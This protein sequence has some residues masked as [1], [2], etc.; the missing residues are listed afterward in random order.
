MLSRDR[1]IIFRLLTCLDKALE[2]AARGL[3]ARGRSSPLR[4]TFTHSTLWVPFTQPLVSWCVW[5]EPLI[6]VPLG[7]HAP[8]RHLHANYRQMYTHPFV[9]RDYAF[10][11]RL[12]NEHE[13]VLFFYFFPS[14]PTHPPLVLFNLI[15]CLLYP[16]HLNNTYHETKGLQV[17]QLLLKNGNKNVEYAL[18]F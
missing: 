7:R 11:L 2:K 13:W 9:Y 18:F 5:P 6:I 15:P 14:F 17:L 16:G 12:W 10:N 3:F 4:G 8:R 1:G